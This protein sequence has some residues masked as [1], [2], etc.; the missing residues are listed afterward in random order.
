[1]GLLSNLFRRAPLPTIPPGP[2]VDELQRWELRR[3]S[4][5]PQCIVRYGHN[6]AREL[7]IDVLGD[8]PEAEAY[9][10]YLLLDPQNLRPVHLDGLGP[11]RG[12]HTRSVE[13]F[14]RAMLTL[15]VRYPSLQSRR[16]S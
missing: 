5:S 7:T 10:R 3:T 16:I 2:V 9:L 15:P 11:Q 14:E 8:D 6:A 12:P 1:M 13:L 4:A